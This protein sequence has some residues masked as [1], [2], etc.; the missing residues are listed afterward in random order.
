MEMAERMTT[1]RFKVANHL[2]DWFEEYRFYHREAG[3]IVKSR[4]DLMSATRIALMA[5]R[6]G[7]AVHLGREPFKRP[8]GPH[9]DGIAEGLDFDLF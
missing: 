6:F 2:S 7:R 8:R 4:D 9:G 1:G 5:K 3:L